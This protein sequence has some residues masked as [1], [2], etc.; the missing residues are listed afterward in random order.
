MWPITYVSTDLLEAHFSPAL[1]QMS[2]FTVITINFISSIIGM[3]FI[4]RY[5][6][7]P[8]LLGF[9]VANT[10]TLV[11]YVVF[12]RLT[13]LVNEDFRYGCILSL[14]SYG[15][16]YG[17][18]L[19]PIAF[20]ITAELIPQHF[21][22]MIQ[23]IVFA[24]NT[25]LNFLFSFATLPLY[26][27]I[28]IWAFIPLFIIPSALSL[29][30]LY[31]EMPETRGR[32]IYEIVKELSS[33]KSSANDLEPTQSTKTDTEDTL[34]TDTDEEDQPLNLTKN[35]CLAAEMGKANVNVGDKKNDCT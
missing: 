6:R 34:S 28:N 15:I 30:Y 19:G 14:V 9:G 20:F 10:L 26:R 31:F 35:L 13:A 24:I 12:D 18:A 22:S 1:A 3:F 21:R 8:L 7:R 11:S 27:M 2:S 25:T 5:G 16:T 33:R 17:F 23:S 4:E 32:E 29:I